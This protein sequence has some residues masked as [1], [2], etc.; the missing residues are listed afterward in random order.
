MIVPLACAALNLGVFADAP[1]RDVP[2]QVKT[3]D[4]L[5]KNFGSRIGFGPVQRAEFSLSGRQVFAVWNC[6]FSG[7]SACY[8]H[9]YYYDPVKLE[10]VL[11]INRFIEGT[12]DLS[13]EMPSSDELIFRDVHGKVVVKESVAQLPVEK[14]YEEK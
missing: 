2:K 3:R 11:F 10:W 1:L 7:R 13:A 9:V 4:E 6:P 12:H 14:W 5:V 8:L